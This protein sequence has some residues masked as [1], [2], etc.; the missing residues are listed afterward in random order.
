M[1]PRDRRQ[2]G[3]SFTGF[4]FFASLLGFAMLLLIRLV[5]V[6]LENYAVK[7]ALKT[8]QA[9]PELLSKGR[10]EIMESL[11]K[12]WNINMVEHA[13]T[14]NVTIVRDKGRL[15][16]RVVYDVTTPILGNV[17]ALVHFDDSIEAVSP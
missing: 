5:P 14:K 11:E 4:L 15:T 3:M 1:A 6:Y 10:L 9:D 16:L 2:Q 17:S 13:T 7:S 12:R 8:L